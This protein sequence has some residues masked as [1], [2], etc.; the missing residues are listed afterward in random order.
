[1]LNMGGGAPSVK[2]PL[3]P[4]PTLRVGPLAL[5]GRIYAISLAAVSATRLPR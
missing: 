4:S 5:R 3:V 2:R 1:M